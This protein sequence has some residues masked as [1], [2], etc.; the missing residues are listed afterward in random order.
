MKKDYKHI[1]AA[2]LGHRK[3]LPALNQ[4]CLHCRGPVPQNRNETTCSST[5][6]DSLTERLPFDNGERLIIRCRSCG[7]RTF[8]R[9]Y[10]TCSEECWRI[11]YDVPVDA[12]AEQGSGIVWVQP[13][14]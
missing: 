10:F 13:Y 12:P 8:S 14:V 7:N 6:R 4:T 9:H 3:V 2:L 1:D 5:C 11:R